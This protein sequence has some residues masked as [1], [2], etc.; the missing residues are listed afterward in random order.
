[1]SR[2][3]FASPA[4][5]A[6]LAALGVVTILYL[7]RRRRKPL[8]VTGL[9][10]W[11]KPR[12]QTAGGRTREKLLRS[13]SFRLDLAAALALALAAGGL[14][15]RVEEARVVAVLDDSFAMRSRDGHTTAREAVAALF[16]ET[17]KRGGRFALI[18]AGERPAVARAMA[19]ARPAEAARLLAGY[20]PVS[21]RGSLAAAVA[22]ARE[23]YGE[24]LDIHVFTNQAGMAYL[25]GVNAGSAHR[26]AGAGGNVA[27]TQLWRYADPERPG[28]ELLAATWRN[29]SEVPAETRVSVVTGGERARTLHSEA[30]ALPPGGAGVLEIAVAGEADQT[31]RVSVASSGEDVIADDSLAFLPPQPSTALTYDLSGLPPATARYVSLALEAAGAKRGDEA[32]LLVSGGEQSDGQ[33]MTVR[34]VAPTEPGVVTPP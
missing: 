32:D 31:W 23:M 18:L 2:L 26:L 4:G 10:L 13:R 7:Y 34:I 8:P 33:T 15:W 3:F 28:V 25:D 9:F 14:S 5:L 27:F 20:D 11:G 29:F 1:M 17:G 30:A 19:E 24:G 6:A 16:A 12:R 21:R 22:L